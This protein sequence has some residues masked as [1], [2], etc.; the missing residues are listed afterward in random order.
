MKATNKQN[1]S[2]INIFRARSKFNKQKKKHLIK[3]K[4]FN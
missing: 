2:R 1:N 4:N 3:S